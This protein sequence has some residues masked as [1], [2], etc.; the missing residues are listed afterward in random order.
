MDPAL[1]FGP[2]GKKKRYVIQGRLYMDLN[3]Y[4]VLGL[5]NLFKPC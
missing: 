1:G 2:K 4:L 3:N 5:K